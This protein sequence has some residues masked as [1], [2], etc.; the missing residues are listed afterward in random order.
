[1][2][3]LCLEAIRNNRVFVYFTF[4]KKKNDLRSQSISTAEIGKN[5]RNCP[6]WEAS[7]V[8]LLDWQSRSKIGREGQ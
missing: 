1:M 7:I 8:Y 4:V 2:F 5:F 6:V 3:S